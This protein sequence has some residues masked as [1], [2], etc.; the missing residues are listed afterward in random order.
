MAQAVPKTR[1]ST[2]HSE[3]CSYLIV[4]SLSTNSE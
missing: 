4:T 2:A 1:T 3:Q